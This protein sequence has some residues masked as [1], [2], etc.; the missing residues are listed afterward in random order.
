MQSRNQLGIAIISAFLL[1]ACQPEQQTQLNAQQSF[2]CKSLIHGFLNAQKLT[3]YEL[4]LI[5]PM[6][7]GGLNQQLYIYKAKSENGLNIMPRQAKLRFAC[8]QMTARKFQIKMNQTQTSQMPET[9]H[10][11]LSIE[12]PEVQQMKDLTAFNQYQTHP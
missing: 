10:T 6:T 2:V 4:E 12:L 1:S 5:Q 3:Q 9:Q 8:E 11:L 7:T